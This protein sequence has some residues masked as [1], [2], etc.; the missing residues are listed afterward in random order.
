MEPY[1]ACSGANCIFGSHPPNGT[2][3]KFGICRMCMSE[4]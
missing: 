1:P 2:R 3:Q 4:H